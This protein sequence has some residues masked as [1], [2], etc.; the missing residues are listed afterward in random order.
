MINSNFKQSRNIRIFIS[1][2][3][4]DL[5]AERNYLVDNIFPLLREMA[6]KRNVSLSEIDL[7]WGIT[8][9]ESQQNK[10]IEICLDEIEY[11]HPFFIGI[12]G[13]RYGWT[14]SKNELL[15]AGAIPPRYAWIEEDLEN[16]LS[17]TEIEMLYGALRSEQKIHASFYLK[18]PSDDIPVDERQEKLKERIRMQEQYTAWGFETLE[19]LGELV[20]DDF[21]AMLNDLFP[22]DGKETALEKE[23]MAQLA[24]INEKTQ[25]YVDD[26]L[27]DVY[28][29]NFLYNSDK[30][31]LIV[32]G[33]SGM[34]KSTRLAHWAKQVMSD[35]KVNVITVFRTITNNCWSVEQ[36]LYKLIAEINDL[37]NLFL[38]ENISPEGKNIKE[39]TELLDYCWKVIEGDKPLLI[40][41][42]GLNQMTDDENIVKQMNWLPQLRKGIKMVFSTVDGDDALTTLINR[43]YP[44]LN[45]LPL[46]ADQKRE[47]MNQYF[48]RYGKRLTKEQQDIVMHGRDITDNTLV[49]VSLL[50]Q[51][52][53]FGE[54]ENLSEFARDMVNVKSEA[55]F[56]KMLLK[57]NEVRYDMGNRALLPILLSAIALS[58]DGLPENIL[59]E[60][61]N[62]PTLYWSYFYSAN[63]MH[64]VTVNGRIS[65]AH[66]MMREAVMN[67]YINN[68]QEFEELIREMIIEHIDGDT[69][70]YAQNELAYQY[71]ALKQY[72]L[73]Y[74]HICT[75]AYLDQQFIDN[76]ITE[77]VIYW[78]ELMLENNRRYR[79]TAYRDEL[80]KL[81]VDDAYNL[82]SDDLMRSTIWLYSKHSFE[83]LIILCITHL[84]DLES[85]YLLLLFTQRMDQ[86]CMSIEKLEVNHNLTGVVC[87]KMGDYVQAMKLFMTQIEENGENG[88][89]TPL[90]NLAE[91]YTCMGEK[92]NNLQY[93]EKASIIFERILQSRIDRY[94]ER[95][96]KVAVAY[97]NLSGIYY[98]L[99][100]NEK[101]ELYGKLSQEIY[102]SL[103]GEN[104]IDVGIEFSN[105]AIHQYNDGNYERAEMDAIK[106][107]KIF[108]KS[109]GEKNMNV[110]DA[111]QL[112]AKIYIA[113]KEYEK[114]DKHLDEYISRL[115]ELEQIADSLNERWNDM[116]NYYYEVGELDKAFDAAAYYMEMLEKQGNSESAM[117]AKLWS[118]IA[119]LYMKQN[120]ESLCRN[121]YLK[122][123]E[124]WH[125]LG[126]ETHAANAEAYYFKALN[127]MGY[128]DEAL[129]WVQTSLKHQ[130]ACGAGR[131]E[132]AAYN[133]FNYGVV[134]YNNG[135]REKALEQ[136]KIAAEIRTELFGTE[137]D[138]A[139]YYINTSEQIETQ[140]SMYP[141]DLVDEN[142]IDRECEEFAAISHDEDLNELFTKGKEAF[143][144][145]RIDSAIHFFETGL[146]MCDAKE[147]DEEDLRRCYLKKMLAFSKE[148]AQKPEWHDEVTNLYLEAINIALN[149]EEYELAQ[150]CCKDLAEYNWNRGIFVDAENYYWEELEILINYNKI[151]ARTIVIC[152][153][154]IT[155]AML[156]QGKRDWLVFL[157]I[158]SVAFYYAT[159][160][161]LEDEI[162]SS[163]RN[164]DF[165]I[166]Q[167][168]EQ[169][170]NF[171]TK[172]QVDPIESALIMCNYMMSLN[173]INIACEF[174][175]SQA[176][177]LLGNQ[178]LNENNLGYYY[179]INM[180]I[181]YL[182]QHQKYYEE[183][184]KKIKILS[185]EISKLNCDITEYHKSIINILSITC[186][187]TFRYQEAIDVATSI[188]MDDVL[189]R[190]VA[191]C[192]TNLDKHKEALVLIESLLEGEIQP[193]LTYL[194]YAQSLMLT[195]DISDG[196]KALNMIIEDSND[197]MML[198][199]TDALKMY[200]YFTMDNKQEYMNLLRDIEKGIDCYYADIQEE[201][202]V[203]HFYARM[204]KAMNLTDQATLVLE[205]LLEKINEEE[206]L[207]LQGCIEE[208]ERLLANI[209]N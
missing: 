44:T 13:D 16:G 96:E 59:I 48:E 134:L 101:G 151:D 122:S 14:P 166:E 18:K 64:F 172:Y 106:A 86:N 205:I 4:K 192:F 163:S 175:E 81:A 10:V 202:E 66:Q 174:L 77:L 39:L 69:S 74:K 178:K 190:N 136:V 50:D 104:H 103:N 12:L 152:L 184:Y 137:D 79:I 31:G 46:L 7:R 183:A 33:K 130:E 99:G 125:R 27:Y 84:E 68:N 126:H 24:F 37:Y 71:H 179:R 116:T 132:N 23:R 62:I 93:I 88:D 165:A 168:V 28:L 70:H 80:T 153:M 115:K 21:E 92:E 197:S 111:H 94:G 182:K 193:D 181:I 169:D 26:E 30:E 1:S 90:F 83:R 135:Q 145:K 119:K 154:N 102:I 164:I 35:K 89:E 20:K 52:R 140:I 72:D 15:E 19:E 129:E 209:N 147:L 73:L 41:L 40:I 109:M 78:K 97:G 185:E 200:V 141:D 123:I 204:L 114:A 131:S 186:R 91:V 176:Y 199:T 100:D 128:I 177:F 42:D 124:M 5:Q 191:I 160:F 156:K 60:L 110:A 113:Q 170:P 105:N 149:H 87:L 187:I 117:A 120:L 47:L 143:N 6:A 107:L 144:S 56:F 61:M 138:I 29:N 76:N 189:K 108:R 208:T 22:E 43:G 95:H 36:T 38:G 57:Q 155:S 158:S 63:R 180:S 121:A 49:L 157:H 34:G 9:E 8:E 17:I 98:Q 85:A 171:D 173:F 148:A 82:E 206:E 51:M 32:K 58:R 162:K 201:A 75:L 112:L 139:Q 194:Y 3:F 55:E 11:S 25:S 150:V 118:D 127:D 196:V 67:K 188:D 203:V 133:H 161:E 65:F 2:T 54:F 195:N 167:L 146:E 142:I 53:R 207:D 198:L 159:R 45:I